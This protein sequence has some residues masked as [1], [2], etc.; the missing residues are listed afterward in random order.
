[1]SYFNKRIRPVWLV[2]PLLALIVFYARGPRRAMTDSGDFATVYAASR[3]WLAHENP[4]LEANIDQQYA[5]GHGD[6]AHAPDAGLTASVYLPSIFPLVAMVAW[7]DWHTAERAWLLLGLVAFAISL[8][9]VARSELIPNPLTAIVLVT[10]FLL[11]SATQTGIAKGQPSVIC[12]S[13]LVAAFYLKQNQRE[14]LLAGLFLGIS[15]CIKPNFALPYM[16][17]CCWR[18]QWR[19]VVVSVLVPLAVSTVALKNLLGL[20]PGWWL[21]WSANVKMASAPGGNM[22]P[23]IANIGSTFLVNF[24]T[25]V[26]FFTTN[27]QICNLITYTL[28]AGLAIALLVITKL[29]I[30]KWQ[31]LAFLTI[32]LL[33]A[34][35]HR[36]YD[37]QLLMLCTNAALQLYRKPQPVVWAGTA[38]AVMLWFPLEA[39][40]ANVLP[41][42]TPAAASFW[43]FLAFR[44]QP[45]C[46]FVIALVFAW[47]LIRNARPLVESQPERLASH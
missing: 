46:L 36:Y 25:V 7:L 38:A 43:Q 5:A 41:Y 21:D 47:A 9:C 33:L 31:A 23:T 18:R 3:C 15:C 40:A 20:P 32:L 1:M 22:N 39:M 42:P 4:Y 29:K 6:P 45:L 11:F 30:D 28:L 44:N 16:L 17:F 35:Y 24:Q 19:V 13:L 37:V 2:L 27:R 10:L 12:I 8:L 34:S 26:G 14:E